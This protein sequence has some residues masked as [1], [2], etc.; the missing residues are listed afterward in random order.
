VTSYYK[1]LSIRLQPQG[2]NKL[3]S[4]ETGVM[5]LAM[6]C[7]FVLVVFLLQGYGGG[8]G[9]MHILGTKRNS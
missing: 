1:G 4:S 2:R 7:H 8:V 6:C 9:E 5:G 3:V